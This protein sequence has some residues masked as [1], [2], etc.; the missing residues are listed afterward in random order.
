VRFSIVLALCALPIA[1]QTL[2]THAY[3]GSGSDAINGV[4]VDFSGNIYTVGTTTSFDLPLLHP[5]Q[6]ANTGTQL[7]YS[8]DAGLTWKPLINLPP[9]SDFYAPIQLAVDPTNPAI[10][11]AGYGYQVYK[12]TDGGR[13]F[14]AGVTLPGLSLSAYI[15]SLAIDPTQPSLLYATS[16][17]GGTVFKST[18]GGATW[19]QLNGLP[20]TGNYNSVVLDPFHPKS[21]W[22]WAGTIGYLSTDGGNTWNDVPLQ[23]QGQTYGGVQFVFDAATPGT[24]YGPAQQNGQPLEVQKSTDGGKTWSM[25]S[26]PFSGEVVADPVRAGYL[27]AIAGPT[28]YRSTDGG[29][30]WQSFPFPSGQFAASPVVDP[31]N[32]NIVVAGTYRSTDNGQ[33][34]SPTAV[35]RSIMA[36]FA[37]SGKGLVYAAAPITSDIFIAKFAPDGKTLLWATYFGGMGDEIA[38]AIQI[39]GSGNV[40]ASGSTTS[41]DLPVSSS[42]LQAQFKGTLNGFLAKFTAD[43]QYLASTYLGGSAAD[44]IKN[45]RIDSSGDVW[46]A[47]STTSPDFPIT[48]ASCNC[49]ANL[50]TYFVFLS[51]VDST[52]SKLLYSA[53]AT[54]TGMEEPGGLSIDPSGNIVITGTT[55]ATNFPVSPNVIHAKPAATPTQNAFLIKFD[56][57]GKTLFSTYLGGSIAAM[58]QGQSFIDNTGVAVATDSGGIY[59]TGNT[60]TLDFP[61]T[62]GAFQT[63]LHGGC[64]YPSAADAT[65]F[66]GTIFT[67]AVDDVF[68]TKLSPDGTK[69]IY[70]T[71]LG[72]SCYDRPTDLVVTP[73][74]SVYVAGET[75]S[76][77]FPLA[78]PLEN[79]PAAEQYESFIA[80]LDATGSTLPFSTYLL[81]GSNPMLALGPD[82]LIHVGGSTGF[83]AQTQTNG[84]NPFFFEMPDTH[85]YLAAIDTTV[86]SAPLDLTAVLNAFSLLP[87]P[88]AP[89]EIVALKVPNFHPTQTVNL[90]FNDQ[91]PLPITL[92]GV[93]VLF[94]G[95]PAPIIRVS[96]GFVVCIAPQSFG[97]QQTTSVQ[98][99][100]QGVSSNALIATVAPTALG[101]LSADGSGQGDANARNA[102]GTLNSAQN[103]A[104]PG[105]TV[106]LYVTGAGMPPAPVTVFDEFPVTLHAM[107]GFV[108][109]IYAVDFQIPASFSTGPFNVALESGILLSQTLTIYIK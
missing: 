63:K 30:N 67:Y 21:L 92:A 101:L 108:P 80:M 23:F 55:N 75:D 39:D 51:E 105:S 4:A 59:L 106:T 44:S 77:D 26:T 48:T 82:G 33:T 5:S 83:L 68:V 50:A 2:S 52:A 28:F 41:F 32:P 16:L 17:D 25:L 78:H 62:S 9:T 79:G 61:I 93:H 104:A 43:G 94:D 87:G 36:E 100:A 97:T 71:Y 22:V 47:G 89:G 107:P 12:S 58:N 18:D 60:S 27:Y 54:T 98:L 24:I 11:Y 96:S 10:V 13:H 40:W 45:L 56:N 29:A 38:S 85:S 31:A 73:A 88:V 95:Q 34:W 90:G 76:T 84:G 42:S 99:D 1:S 53:Y 91:Q 86:M 7:V 109:G 49:L 70:S 65:G 57:S 64:P 15:S 102:D 35:S 37:P 14:S 69:L 6:A 74:G 8:P 20:A 103:P 81:A 72:G 19:V 3:G 66:I 46:M